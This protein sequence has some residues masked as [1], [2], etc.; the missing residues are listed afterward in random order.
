MGQDGQQ[1]GHRDGRGRYDGELHGE[2]L[3]VARD[4]AAAVLGELI[5]YC[6][7]K[8]WWAEHAG[9]VDPVAVA[10][11]RDRQAGYALE[12]RTLPRADPA[13]IRTVLDRRGR[14]LRALQTPAP[15][16]SRHPDSDHSPNPDRAAGPG[17]GTRGGF[18][19]GLRVVLVPDLGDELVTVL[20]RVEELLLVVDDAAGA[21]DDLEPLV[22]PAPLAGRV[23]LDA[24]ARV[25][26]AVGP[27]QT[28]TDRPPPPG[29]RLLGPD[30]R[31]ERRP[32]RLVTL[33]PADLHVLAAA[34]AVLGV[35]LATRSGSELCEAMDV[36][37]DAA[38]EI[39]P[40]TTPS[41]AV[42]GVTP[43]VVPAAVSSGS[44]TSA[45]SLVEAL[46]RAHGLL[47][48]VGTDDTRV[49]AARVADLDHGD[50]V[51]NAA[52]DAA[53]ERLA[54]RFTTMWTSADPPTRWVH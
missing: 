15:E 51:L 41:G 35:E 54:G 40:S 47:D 48:L 49:L 12:R 39:T 43:D 53:Y 28:R 32:L 25:A 26:A 24:L 31:S 7:A 3:E 33:D 21:A 1:D 16:G 45:A 4:T 27:T 37:A 50:V 36:G 29:G 14:E 23:A 8:L 52:E 17:G 10:A 44:P 20:A 46:A 38:G 5:G 22:L 2:D 9:T 42:P 6:S 11:W 19:F 34:A 30:G 18:S 13:A